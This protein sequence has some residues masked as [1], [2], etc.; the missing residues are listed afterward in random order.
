MLKRIP[1][2]YSSGLAQ[3]KPEV[4]RLLTAAVINTNFRSMLLA[5]PARAIASGYQGEHFQLGSR[6]TMQVSSIH[7]SNLADFAARLAD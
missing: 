2:P 3:A 1:T 7:A 4:S 6:E 5:D